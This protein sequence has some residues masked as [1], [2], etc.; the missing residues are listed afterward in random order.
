MLDV[1][2]FACL[3]RDDITLCSHDLNP[4]WF[5]AINSG[6]SWPLILKVFLPF[7]PSDVNYTL[8]PSEIV[9]QLRD[10][11]FLW[12]F[13]A[14]AVW[15]LSSTLFCFYVSFHLPWSPCTLTA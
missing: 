15:S 2:F 1:Y 8:G 5:N 7:S 11:R 14:V 4:S 13:V 10:A 9:L 6:K 3:E 12:V